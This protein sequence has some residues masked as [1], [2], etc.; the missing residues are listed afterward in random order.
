MVL[1]FIPLAITVLSRRGILDRPEERS[2]HSKP[3][4]RGAGLIT[5]LSLTVALAIGFDRFRLSLAV[6]AL[7]ATALGS[8]EDL[9]GIGVA[10]RL[11][12]QF[13]IGAIFL[14]STW[15]LGTVPALPLAIALIVFIAG[16]TNAFNFMDGI[17]GISS[18]AATVAGGS[19]IALGTVRR[20][21]DLA[22]IGVV[23]IV[24]AV[25]FL[26]FNFPRARVFLGD[27][28]SYSFGAVI[29]CAAVAAWRLGIP[30]D[31]VLAPLAIY[32]ADTATVILRR[33]A[34]RQPLTAAH[35]EH[36]FQRL[37]LFGFSHAEST[38]VVF[39]GS[40]ATAVLGLAAASSAT[41]ERIALD[42]LIIGIVLLYLSLPKLVERKQRR[43]RSAVGSAE[44]AAGASP[45]PSLIRRNR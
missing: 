26:P 8:L 29:A 43:Q 32:L 3:T 34:R 2:S 31:A 13:G 41:P 44:S 10:Q 4:P 25:C 30:A 23:L 37:L 42:A 38:G 24:V 33:A 27:S 14:A 9:R 39:L 40:L 1:A 18:A 22:L 36:A 35:R 15:G 20:I 7:L 5:G 21:A 17:N 16:Y 28:G 19:F 45:D 12:A 6:V 11:V